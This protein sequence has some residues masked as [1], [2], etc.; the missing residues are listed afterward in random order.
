MKFVDQHILATFY[1]SIAACDMCDLLPPTDVVEELKTILNIQFD[2]MK[3]ML[4]SKHYGSE[5]LSDFIEHCKEISV[6]WE[7]IKKD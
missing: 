2:I 6:E 5:N 7:R 4:E 1:A 3:T